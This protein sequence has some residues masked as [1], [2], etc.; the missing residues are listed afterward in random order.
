M[1]RTDFRTPRLYVEA[2]LAE[3][4]EV[5]L[6]PQQTNYLVNVLRLGADASRASVQWPRRRIRKRARGDF[7]QK[8][9]A[10]RRPPHAA[11]GG[12]AGRRLSVRAAQARPP[13]L[14][15][16]EG[17]RDGGAAAEAAHHPAHPDRA[18]QSRAPARQRH[19]SLRAMRR[20]LGARG[21]RAGDARKGARAIGRP[22]RL[23]VFCD[24]EA[25]Q[26]SPLDALGE[27]S[28][29]DG[30]GL[31]VGPEGGF[32]DDERAAILAAPRV[33]AP[34][35]RPADPARGHGGGGGADA[36]PGHARRL[37]EV[38]PRRQGLIFDHRGS[39]RPFCRHVL[40]SLQ[41]VMIYRQLGK[42]RGV[43]GA[44]SFARGPLFAFL[45]GSPSGLAS[46]GE[47]D[48]STLPAAVASP[49]RCDAT[50]EGPGV[51]KDSG[52]CKRIS[53]YIAAGAR[54]GKMSKLA[55]APPPSASSRRRNSSAACVPPARRSS[56]LPR[57]RTAC[58]CL[59]AP[60]TRRAEAPRA[61]LKRR[62][63]ESRIDRAAPRAFV[64]LE[65][66]AAPAHGRSLRSPR[67]DE[68]RSSR[69][70]PWR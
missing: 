58:S 7:A 5:K 36:H 65:S 32:D 17:G 37:A 20:D 50:S 69:P 56:T 33:L 59:P 4:A 2:P 64:T 62:L 53:G 42:R 67:G 66:N 41:S 48:R 10:R 52:D 11:A 9:V 46:A 30:V 63:V 16:A 47:F 61:R 1:A 51:L 14:Y 54:S 8:R 24:E 40:A 13:R 38:A 70:R 3:G 25:P 15:G 26:A 18:R 68:A 23:I 43:R 35:P 12:A 57:A 44:M 27:V 39:R 55:A 19:R 21:R 29:E 49:A 22:E 34:E 45:I 60:A 31:L 6:D 28:A